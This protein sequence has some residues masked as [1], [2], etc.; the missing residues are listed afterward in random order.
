MRTQGAFSITSSMIFLARVSSIRPH[1][2]GLNWRAHIV[3]LSW[4][5]TRIFRAG[6]DLGSI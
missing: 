6:P 5:K 2:R 1:F 4:Q 3:H